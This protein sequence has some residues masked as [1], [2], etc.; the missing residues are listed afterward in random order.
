MIELI[1]SLFQE[2]DYIKIF[3]NN[4]SKSVEG[5]ILK[6]VADSMALQKPD[7]K[8]VGVKGDD[9]D[10][11]EQCP[12]PETSK[13]DHIVKD[14]V[15]T[16]MEEQVSNVSPKVESVEKDKGKNDNGNTGAT[17]SITNKVDVSQLKPGDVIP[18]EQLAKIDPKIKNKRFI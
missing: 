14:E 12:I 18:L 3:F 7:G 9:I 2:G 17:T 13:H 11:F 15:P 1:L 4:S 8:I 6:I 10:S 5:R 16:V